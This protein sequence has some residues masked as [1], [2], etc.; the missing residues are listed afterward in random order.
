MP[1]F[2]EKIK[3]WAQSFRTFPDDVHR[4]IASFTEAELDKSYRVGGWT[5]R[6]IVHHLAD[7]HSIGL[8]RAKL[9]LTE[10]KPILKPFDQDAW[11]DLADYRL[12]VTASMAW[13]ACIHEHWAA[14]I[15]SLKEEDLSR[16]GIHLE[17]GLVTL[18]QIIEMFAW[19]G[20][21]HL[22]QIQS[23]KQR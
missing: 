19:H 2:D 8:I 9:V 18:E 4:V 15:E 16:E 1:T 3:F 6:Q 5:A 12:P 23:I 17:R 21:H 11:A 22:A 7:A 20:P 14:L 13:L 10:H